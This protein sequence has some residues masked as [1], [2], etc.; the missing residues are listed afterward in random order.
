MSATARH[1]WQDIRDAIQGRILDRTWR[2]GDK[3]PRDEDIARELGCSRSTVQRAMQ[4][5]A[6]AGLV[7]RKR[8]GGTQV[9]PD[10][11]SRA[12]L[13]IPITRREVEA[14]GG[15][16]GYQLV[17]RTIEDTPPRVAA[18]FGLSAPRRML[19]VAALHLADQRP[20]IF[21][22]RWVCVETVPEILDADLSRISANEWLVLNKPYDRYDLRLFAVEADARAARQL[23]TRAGAAL[24]VMERT[25]WISGAP[26]TNVRAVT[27]PGYQLI[28]QS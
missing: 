5:L 15:V 9:R 26:I 2:P 25:T 1:R 27:A 28:T 10:P 8:K 16:Y 24:L 3:L 13:D 23:D 4:D 17:E 20:Y 11:V 21:E 14:R 18:A 7:E 12:T 19:R 22:D 6:D